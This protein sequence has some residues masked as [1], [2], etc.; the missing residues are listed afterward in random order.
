MLFP[1]WG[2]Y[3]EYIHV[4]V[5]CE[6]K[7]SFLSCKYLISPVDGRVMWMVCEWLA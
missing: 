1:V 7:F 4:R 3:E 6:H 2:C 5:L